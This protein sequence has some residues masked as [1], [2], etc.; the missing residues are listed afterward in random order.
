M[1]FG[2]KTE[3][4]VSN[5]L[6][7]FIYSFNRPHF[8]IHHGRPH[9]SILKRICG[10][11]PVSRPAGRPH[12]RY[13]LS[14]HSSVVTKQIRS[15]PDVSSAVCPDRRLQILFLP[16]NC[17]YVECTT[18]IGDPVWDT[19]FLQSSHQWLLRP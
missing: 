15:R 4:K 10:R 7:W 3:V 17:T 11:P 16:G 19:L 6:D 14:C 8:S 9:F 12:F 2:S 13:C 5:R 18:S 1:K